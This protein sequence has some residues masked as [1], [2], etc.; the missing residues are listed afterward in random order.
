MA[1]P[2]GGDPDDS[3]GDFVALPP[4]WEAGRDELSRVD[5][6]EPIPTVAA[7]V[8]G[9][10]R[11]T[12]SELTAEANSEG[13]PTGSGPD[14]S[15][16]RRLPQRAQDTDGP[17]SGRFGLGLLGR[18]D[19]EGGRVV[20][21]RAECRFD[22]RRNLLVGFR[23]P[24]VAGRA[25]EFR[26]LDADF[27]LLDFWGTWC[28]PCLRAVPE[29][30]ALQTRYD[31]KRLR[32]V[33]V[34]CERG[35]PAENASEVAK[36][37]RRLGVNYTL[38]MADPQGDTGASPLAEALNVREFPTLVLLDRHGRVLWRDSGVGPAGIAKLERVVAANAR[39][40]TVRR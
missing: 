35:E 32:V 8:E 39:G 33:G 18:R 26:N 36:A 7:E 13:G 19:E 29:L 14:P 31:P 12:W 1:G 9:P 20:P 2:S 25:V 4:S 27:V 17:G 6:L 21:V 28:G 24:D 30:A 11:P 5:P 16:V 15:S 34:A 10:T 22:S 37:A 38:L 3:M 40:E 23:L